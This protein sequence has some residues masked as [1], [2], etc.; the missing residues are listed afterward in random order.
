MMLRHVG[1]ALMALTLVACTRGPDQGTV[2]ADLQRELDSSFRLGLFKVLSVNTQGWVPIAGDRESR[3]LAYHN[4]QIEFLQPYDLGSWGD[5]GL[6]SLAGVVGAAKKG[7]TGVKPGGNAQGDVLKVHGRTTYQKTDA[8][9]EHVAASPPRRA[10]AQGE[11]TLDNSAP[12]SDLQAMAN[13]IGDRAARARGE[14][15]AIMEQELAV[16]LRKIN[17]RVDAAE[18]TPA[19]MSGPTVGEYYAMGRALQQVL[20]TEGMELHNYDS[21]GSIENCEQVSN[22][23]VALALVQNDIAAMAYAG[24][25][26]FVNRAP[27]EN[28]RAVASLFPE[29]VQVVVT[30][31]SGIDSVAGLRGKRVDLGAPGSGSRVN[32]AQILEAHGIALSD[33]AEASELG[34]ADAVDALRA[35]E[36]DAL[37]TTI[38]TPSR[39]LQALAA[40]E[41]IR[42]LSLDPDALSELVEQYPYYVQL[43]VPANTYPGG[44][45][46]AAQT[47]G[48]TAMLIAR[49]DVGDDTVSTLLEGLFDSV[50]EISRDSFQGARISR[51]TAREGITIP[52]HPG[53]EKVLGSD[54]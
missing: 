43:T 15:A 26:I 50:G 31:A 6:G 17:L 22:G 32:A 44:Q 42:I 1:I 28:L 36:L 38:A 12:P 45:G 7:I 46:K 9:W 19:L 13:Q 16:A 51:N 27:M 33:L 25:G 8:G 29:P 37:V 49:D 40:D 30:Q 3:V 41:P 48:V 10:R 2:I 35:G 21:A 23:V 52:L 47:V 18:G 14:Q 39:F 20:G 4:S 34:L 53:A 5:V 24:D 54:G 11:L